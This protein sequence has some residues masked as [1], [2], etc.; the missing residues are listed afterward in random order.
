MGVSCSVDPFLCR[1]R[2]YHKGRESGRARFRTRERS[3]LCNGLGM[4]YRI[5][6]TLFCSRLDLCRWFPWA[7]WLR[8]LHLSLTHIVPTSALETL[9]G[10]EVRSASFPSVCAA[11]RCWTCNLLQTV[12]WFLRF[13][14]NRRL[15]Y[16]TNLLLKRMFPTKSNSYSLRMSPR[17]N[18][19]QHTWR[20]KHSTL[21][22]SY[23]WCN[24]N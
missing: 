10:F 7:R 11:L 15:P 6:P 3:G 20:T 23:Q 8:P 22:Y 16:W 21:L 2:V 17:Q 13:F 12:L 24:T 18:K 9:R 19:P 4:L 1:G 14:K 5:Q